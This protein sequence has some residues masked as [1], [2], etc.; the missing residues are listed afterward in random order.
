MRIRKDYLEYGVVVHDGQGVVG[1][2][3]YRQRIFARRRHSQIDRDIREG[4]V[5]EHK[6]LDALIER[7]KEY[8][9]A[10]GHK[11]CRQLLCSAP[12]STDV[13]H[14]LDLSLCRSNSA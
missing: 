8:C 12:L 11:V 13:E 10:R 5:E 1:T 3:R 9:E 7:A 4:K 6:L 2:E 14:S